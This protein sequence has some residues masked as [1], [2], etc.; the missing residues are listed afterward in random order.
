MSK[1]SFDGDCDDRSSA[2]CRQ[3]LEMHELW[4]G[5]ERGARASESIRHASVAVIPLQSSINRPIDR[6]QRPGEPGLS[7]GAA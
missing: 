7:R 2:R 6:H 5:L 1:L 4:R 3:L